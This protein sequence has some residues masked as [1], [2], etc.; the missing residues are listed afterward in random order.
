MTIRKGNKNDLAEMKQLFAGTITAVCKRDYSCEQIEAWKSGADNEERWL[1][2]IQ[3]QKVL[4]ALSENKIIGFCT[5]HKNY[6]D[7]LFV[8]QDYQHQ[9]VAF[10]L[11]TQTEKEAI[12]QKE[13]QLTADVSTTAK[14]FFEKMGF[15]V[16]SQQTVKV[17][18]VDLINYKMEKNLV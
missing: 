4:I 18:G 5:L 12:K 10:T 17:K 2:V 7:L 15:Q 6:I 13:Q 1:K 8:H 14:P 9:G 3:D 16:I 11:Y